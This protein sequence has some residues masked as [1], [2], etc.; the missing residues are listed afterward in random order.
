MKP[1]SSAPLSSRVLLVP[2]VLALLAVP[3]AVPGVPGGGADALAQE[4]PPDT[5]EADTIEAD[6]VEADTAEEEPD[7]PPY[8]EVIHEGI[9]SDTGVFIAHRAADTLFYEI[10]EDQFGREFLWV[11]RIAEAQTGTG[12]GG[13]KLNS[14]VVRWE[15]RGDRVLLR[16]VS[17]EVTADSTEPIYR[18]VRSASLEPVIAAFEIETFSPEDSTPVVRVTDLF[19]TDVPEF[20]PRSRLRASSLDRDRS[21]LEEVLSFP[22]NIEVEALL[23]FRSDSV[24]GVSGAGSIFGGADLGTISVVMHHSMVR[25]PADPMRPR[26]ADDRVGYFEV[27]QYD[28]GMDEHRAARRRMINRWR[29]EPRD[30]GAIERGELTEPVE[31]IVY[32][33]DPATP[34]KW[35]PWLKRGVEEWQ[36]AFERAGFRNA[37]VARDAPTPE[38]D[39]EWHPEDARHS[40][41]RWLPSTVENAS[42]P[43]VHD[44]RTGEILES[45]I[46]WYHNV[47]NLLR[48]W[49][50]VQAGPLD[51]RAAQLPLPDSLMGRLVQ[52]VAAHEV[53]HTLGFYHNMKASSAYPVDSLRSPTFTERY[54]T[55]ASIMDYGR[56]NYIAQPGDDARLIPK[57]GPYDEFAVMWGYRP[58]PGA[59]TAEQEREQ[60]DEWARMQDENPFYLFGHA[61]SH[62]PTAQT[63]DLG[64]DPVKATGYGVRNIRRVMDMLVEAAGRP[65]E[66]YEDLRELYRETVGQWRTEMHHVVPV[67]G[68]VVRTEKRYGQEGDVFDPVP[69]DRQREAV[70]FLN[71]EAFRPPEYLVSPEVLR[72]VEPEGAVDRIRS[73]QAGLLD[74]LLDNERLSRLIEGETVTGDAEPYPLPEMLEDVR[75]GVWSELYEGDAVGPYRRNLQRAW[76]EDM[77]LK[78]EDREG[79]SFTPGQFT[80]RFGPQPP[81]YP[82]DIRAAARGE[83]REVA[84]E[85]DARLDGVR[86]RMTR[87]HLEDVRAEIRE[88][89]GE[90]E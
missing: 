37:I 49:Y 86:D 58:V 69:G 75:R 17:Y 23:T 38:E 41:I 90:E 52:Y 11:A 83:L 45:D 20:S 32:Y 22:E 16:N 3:L 57:V 42:G 29:L 4:G 67:V 62:D 54:G 51:D 56:F 39:P 7:F 89:L 1:A 76:V 65:G 34:E 31:P 88:M 43:H 27:R 59:S 64:D 6:T 14:R 9:A 48:N 21:F 72:L 78:L 26:L 18:A 53:G 66:S 63:E 8:E 50:F 60:L 24:P 73:L 55:E 79:G 70:R 47:M 82:N 35:R 44:P 28:F 68:G 2:F 85:I 87:M 77:A 40:V 36:E 71:Q 84:R 81:S 25:L 19:T 61:R 30:P 33:I 10:P 12:Y 13:Q 15:R 74:E 80:I 5:V 46:Q